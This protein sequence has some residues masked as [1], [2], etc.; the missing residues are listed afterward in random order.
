MSGDHESPAGHDDHDG[1]GGHDKHA[2]HSV[3]PAM[4]GT[5]VLV[6][7]GTVFLRGAAGELRDRRPG[8]MAPISLAIV[9]AFVTSW[10][11]TRVPR[12]A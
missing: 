4:L 3:L 10:A 8:M 2:G 1:H 6:Y 9:V 5:V 7:G 11:G 12:S